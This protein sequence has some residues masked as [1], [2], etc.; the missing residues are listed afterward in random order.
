[1]TTIVLSGANMIVTNAAINSSYGGTAHTEDVADPSNGVVYV[2][3]STTTACTEQYT[4]FNVTYSGNTSCGNA[5]VSTSGTGY[6]T[7]LTIGTDNDI[8]IN[9]NILTPVNSSGV[10]TGTALLGL[11]ADNFVRVEHPVNNRSGTTGGACGSASNAS[12]SLTNPTIY[13][14][15]L[16]VNHSFI[17]DNYDC[18]STLGTLKVYGAIAQLFRGPVGT[19]NSST[20][21]V[22]GY[23]KDYIYDDRLATAEP[24]YF[25]NPVSAAWYV[26]RQTECDNASACGT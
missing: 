17:V 19:S 23:T 21:A 20:V 2:S 15:I 14:A 5:Y 18:G 24:P 8:I 3:S 7:A 26:Q 22:S 1:V 4:P 16:A 12:G 9:G 13:A 10:P 6:T 11:I 25:L